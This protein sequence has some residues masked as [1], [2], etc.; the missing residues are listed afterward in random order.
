MPWLL[1][2][3]ERRRRNRLQGGRLH[4]GTVAGI[5]SEWWPTSPRNR[6]PACVGILN[7]SRAH[8]QKRFG[9]GAWDFRAFLSSGGEHKET[10]TRLDA[11]E[12]VSVRAGWEV[13]LNHVSDYALLFSDQASEGGGD[14][15]AA[16][17]HVGV[18]LGRGLRVGAHQW[19]C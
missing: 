4:L 16:L 18:L 7:L 5:K 14:Q 12:E 15:E 2:R 19:C 11:D 13:A 17:G 6:W 9:L 10:V 8:V 1:T 3:G